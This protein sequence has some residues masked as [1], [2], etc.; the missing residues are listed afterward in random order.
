MFP[1]LKAEMARKGIHQVD[2]AEELDVTPATMSL[3]LTGKSKL[4]LDEAF[5][6]KK[7]VRTRL[8]LDVLFA[9]TEVA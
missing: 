8:S 9:T 2:L 4:T 5:A 3:K 1:N 7:Y 6:I